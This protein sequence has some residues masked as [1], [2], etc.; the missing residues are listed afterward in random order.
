MKIMLPPVKY[1]QQAK[2]LQFFATLADR[3][4]N[5][6]GVEAVG[7]TNQLP[8]RGGWGGS[9]RV[10]HPEVSMGPDDDSDFQ[11]V[12]PGYF[13]ALRIR[14]LNGRLFSDV[15]RSGSH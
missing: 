12:S 1:P 8:M 5:L 2:R 10:E 15:D 11:I 9:F 7:Y 14:L 4:G 13:T 3:V 6:P